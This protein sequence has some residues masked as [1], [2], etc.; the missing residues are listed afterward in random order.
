MKYSGIVVSRDKTDYG[1]AVVGD[2]AVFKFVVAIIG[3]GDVRVLAALTSDVSEE[4]VERVAEAHHANARFLNGIRTRGKFKTEVLSYVRSLPM[5]SRSESLFNVNNSVVEKAEEAVTDALLKAMEH[6]DAFRAAVA[7]ENATPFLRADRRLVSIMDRVIAEC[8]SAYQENE[9]RLL[10]EVA[11]VTET[12]L[13]ARS[14]FMAEQISRVKGCV[15]AS[16]VV[17]GH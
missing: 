17:F 12:K 2:D 3:S 9:E 7:F 5:G 16:R 6:D 15:N 10:G 11:G 13:A 14:E 1:Y 4:M 8:V